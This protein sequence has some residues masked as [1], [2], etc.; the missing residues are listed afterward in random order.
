[1][2]AILFDL[3]GVIYQGTR[4]IDGAAGVID[5]VRRRSI[6]HLFVTNTS[7]R[8]RRAIVEKLSAM[9]IELAAGELLTPAVA[10][11]DWLRDHRPGPAALF[12]REATRSEFEGLELLDERVESG[13][14]AVVVGDMGDRWDFHTLNRA[15]R[16]LMGEPRPQL[17][18]LG[19]TRYWRAEDG[20]RL[21]TAP[22]VIALS[23]A[24]GAEPLVLGKPARAFFEAAL[25]RLGMNSA[26]TLMIGD[27][28]LGDIQG[29]QKAGLRAML[30]RTGKF[31]PE[32]LDSSIDPDAVVDSVVD[33]P[34]WWQEHQ[35]GY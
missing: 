14:G 8:P 2:R 17:I 30:V 3:D 7:S 32:D 26:N 13:A 20:L 33:L 6:P 11:T 34:K 15:F 21:D 35:N 25:A 18:A 4:P 31:R 12:V 24:S 28:I 10:A 19:M 1:M 23:H 27:D 16:L 29:A 9:G 22:F 5:W